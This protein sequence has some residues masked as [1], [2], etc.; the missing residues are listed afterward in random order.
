MSK[1]IRGKASTESLIYAAACFD[2]E[3]SVTLSRNVRNNGWHTTAIFLCIA[4][5]DWNF[6]SFFVDT[7]GGNVVT[8]APVKLSKRTIY[9]WKLYVRDARDF[10]EMVLPYLKIKQE[11]AKFAIWFVDNKHLLT[12]K[13]RDECWQ[14]MKAMNRG[15][16][17]PA[18]TNRKDVGPNLRSDSP[19][20][21]ETVVNM[22]TTVSSLVSPISVN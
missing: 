11:R 13:Q 9:R 14:Q 4:N 12:V 2:C 5:I 10:L 19:I 15:E 16:L 1:L 8:E 20:L 18:E 3:G 7:F 21:Q 22:E 17:L 6:I